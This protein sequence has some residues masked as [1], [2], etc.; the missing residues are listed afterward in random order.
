MSDLKV[1]DLFM[2]LTKSHGHRPSG[3]EDFF[4]G[5]VPYMGM[6]AILVCDQEH[7]KKNFCSPILTSLHMKFEFNWPS[8]FTEDL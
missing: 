1:W 3:S 2:L 7:L 8:G 6:A 4:K 5:F